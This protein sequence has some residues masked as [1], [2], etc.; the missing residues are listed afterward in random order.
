MVMLILWGCM[1]MFAG[2]P[3]SAWIVLPLVI[4]LSG[5]LLWTVGLQP[6]QQHRIA[7]FLRP[8][9]D[10]QGSGYNAAQARIAIGSGGWLGKGIGEGSQARLRFLPEAATDFIFSVIGEELGFVS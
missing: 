3:R 8:Q 5:A 10:L 1:A 4:L 9:S 2:L 6:Y 7:A